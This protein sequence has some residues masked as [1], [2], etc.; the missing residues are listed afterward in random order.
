MLSYYDNKY[1]YIPISSKYDTDTDT[2]TNFKNSSR[3]DIEKTFD[4]LSNKDNLD[5]V[6]TFW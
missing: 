5:E 3:L 2:N 1:N 4:I 6:F